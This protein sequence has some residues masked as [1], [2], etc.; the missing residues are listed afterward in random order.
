VIPHITKGADMRGLLGY[1]CSTSAPRDE[2]ANQH[3]EPRV[4]GGDPFLEAAFG[5]EDL[6][7]AAAGEVAAYLDEPRRVYGTEIRAKV[8]AHADDGRRVAVL[9]DD[10]RQQF[11]D[12]NVWHCSLSLADG[13]QLSA[14]QWQQV[15]REFA[16]GMGL[17]EASGKAPCRWVA[18]HHGEGRGGHDRVQIAA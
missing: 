10:G 11:R 7:Q 12:E 5:A 6:D 4:V 18:I 14:E 8:W 3:T 15:T 9:D 13:E 16:D 2:R 1:L 17:T